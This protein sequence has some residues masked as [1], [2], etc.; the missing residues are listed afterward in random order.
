MKRFGGLFIMF[1]SSIIFFEGVKYL[2]KIIGLLTSKVEI[3]S[4]DD[5]ITE[6]CL[7]SIISGLTSYL[8]YNWGRKLY[9][10]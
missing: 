1:L 6:Y 3:Q 5:L 8:L 4:K 9:K 2:F 10:L 7:T